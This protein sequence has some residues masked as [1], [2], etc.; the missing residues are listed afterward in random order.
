MRSIT[1]KSY[2]APAI[3]ASGHFV[4]ETRRTIE[5]LQEIDDLHRMLSAGS[6]GFAL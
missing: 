2:E 4:E 3:R 5:G 1:K 6:V